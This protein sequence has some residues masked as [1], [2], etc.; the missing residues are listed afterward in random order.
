MEKRFRAFGLKGVSL[1]PPLLLA[2]AFLLTLRPAEAKTSDA[3]AKPVRKAAVAGMFYPASPRDLEATVD[4]ALAQAKPPEVPGAILGLVVPHAGYQYSGWVAA[5]GFWTLEGRDYDTVIL[6]GNSH[7]DSFD[8]ISVFPE[9]SFETP[10]GNVEVDGKTARKIIDS[11]PKVLARP[12]SHERDHILEVEL[13][14]LQRVLKNFKIVP[15]VFGDDSPELPPILASAL[16]PL[17]TDKTLIV[18]S[19]DMSHYPSGQDA[20]YADHKTLSAI[21]SG[22]AETLAASLEHLEARRI[23]QAET[24]LCGVS[25]VKTLMLLAGELGYDQVTL[26]KYA[27]SGDVSGD[28]S[29]VVGYGALAFSRKEGRGKKTAGALNETERKRLLQIARSTVETYVTRGRL[30][31]IRD[32]D[33]ALLRPSGAFVTLRKHGMLRGCIGRFEADMPLDRTVAQMALAAAI[34]DPRF[35]PMRGDELKDVDYEISVLSPLKRVKNADEIVAGVHGVQVVR[36]FRSGVFLPQVAT[37]N[38]WDRDTFLT[39]LC[40]GKAGLEPDCWK[41]PRTAL[42][43]FTAEVFSEKD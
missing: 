22:N 18:A 43:V 16:K 33:P 8:G 30:P 13:P 2:A 25:A 23:P 24:F 36:D 32:E 5:Y 14:F 34:Q 41:D 12:G 40:E 1:A 39:E 17:V 35:R 28:S 19:T 37:E 7:A 42:S 29:R 21:L 26:L 6:I 9:G 38:G 4:R 27:N 31:E 10:L 11:N 15:I 20:E 3:P